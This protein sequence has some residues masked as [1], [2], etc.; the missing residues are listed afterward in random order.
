[1]PEGCELK[2]LLGAEVGEEPTLRE[3]EPPGE[4]TDAQAL[5]PDLAGDGERVVEDQRFGAIA[6][7]H[8]Q[9]I[10]R[11]FVSLQVKIRQN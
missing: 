11:T 3:A 5:E 2:I 8:A 6:L 4:R 7:S 1:M 10:A 9:K